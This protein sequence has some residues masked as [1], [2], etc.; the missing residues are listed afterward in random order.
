MR[1]VGG[2]RIEVF[3]GRNRTV[4]IADIGEDPGEFG[5]CAD[6]IGNERKN[7]PV[8]L[9]GLAA[10]VCRCQRIGEVQVC[11]RIP[12]GAL[13]RILED[14]HCFRRLAV[15]A[16]G[17]PQVYG[18][19]HIFRFGVPRLAEQPD[20]GLRIV[21]AQSHSAENIQGVGFPGNGFENRIAVARGGIEVARLKTAH[22]RFK[23]CLQD[24]AFGQKA[25]PPVFEF[26]S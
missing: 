6:M 26:T 13:C 5:L 1:V 9:R 20:G 8:T 11:R 22:C 19:F 24:F 14:A 12:G 23:R 4:R 18:Y 17:G 7:A 16:I 10:S 2:E 25:V 15:G 3:I 21:L